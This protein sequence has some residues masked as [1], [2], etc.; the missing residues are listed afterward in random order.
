[1][2][3]LNI[4]FKNARITKGYSL[5]KLADLTG[6]NYQ[7]INR[8]EN[9]KD[10]LSKDNLIKIQ[11][12][13]EI[14]LDQINLVNDKINELFHLFYQDLYYESIDLKA[15]EEQLK[16]TTNEFTEDNQKKY[17]M[18]YI[19]FVM[20]E[21][22]EDC[23]AL[24]RFIDALVFENK[25]IEA[26]YLDYKGSRLFMQDEHEKAIEAFQSALQISD[27]KQIKSMIFF[28]SSFVY[29]DLNNYDLA[30]KY[31]SNAKDIFYENSNYS[32][33]LSC[34]IIIASIYYRT[35]NFEAAELKY[36]SCVKT[37]EMLNK[38]KKDIALIYRNL[39][40]I[41]IRL[42]SYKKSLY[43]LEKSKQLDTNNELMKLYYIWNYYKL[44]DYKTALKIADEQNMVNKEYAMILKLFI[45]LIVLEEN[46]PTLKIIN[47]AIKVYEYAVKSND[48]DLIL[49]YIDIVIDLLERKGDYG[50]MSAYQSKKINLLENINMLHNS[51]N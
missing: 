48:V 14:D 2:E 16:R 26:I 35:R 3:K 29:K 23:Q 31:I 33:L 11:K 44:K 19:I 28:H 27:N 37:A 25:D 49:F 8:F 30:N 13:L 47:H 40:W 46:R 51:T 9:G 24:E 17:V 39:S 22:Y 45:E 43:Y 7:Q 4:I 1:M 15:Y 6:I 42:N 10:K 36:F 41:M 50:R 5:R 20:K 18:E 34:D 12:A 38:D 21:E 32:R